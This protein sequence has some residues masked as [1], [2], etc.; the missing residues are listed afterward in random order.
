MATPV[1]RIR[2]DRLDERAHDPDRQSRRRL[3]EQHHLRVGDERASDR[4][5]LLLAAGQRAGEL[6][7]AFRQPGKEL[8]DH[9]GGNGRAAARGMAS[10]QQ[11]LLD[12]EIG[13]QLAQ[14]RN[15][16]QPA[17]NDSAGV[18]VG[19]VRAVEYHPARG[20][21]DQAGDR[22]DAGGL[23]RSVRPEQSQA[24]AFG[25]R[26]IQSVDADHRPTRDAKPG[27]LQHYAAASRSPK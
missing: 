27:Y 10:R 16:C 23:A 18:E 11:G 14:L 20:L 25:E 24:A 1:S 4:E 6:P 21:R 17:A 7:A 3:V 5:H 13:E 22:F 26:E 9:V 19:D 12:R 8:V 2:L 15:E